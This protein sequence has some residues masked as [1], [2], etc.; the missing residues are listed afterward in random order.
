MSGAKRAIR[1]TRDFDT[2]AD[3]FAAGKELRRRWPRSGH[4]FW[5]P[6]SDRPDPVELI[7]R[8]DRG[9]VA[10]LLP[11]RYGRMARSPFDFLRGSAAVMA[12]NFAQTPVT[13]PRVQL[14]G[15]A[16]LNNFGVFA[17]PERDQVFDINDFDETLPG[18][19]EWD[20]KR[21]ATSL[22]LAGRQNRYTHD[23][24]R[25]VTRRAVRSYRRALARYARM[26]YLTIWHTHFDLRGLPKE[27]RRS[28]GKEITRVL[29]KGRHRTDFNAFPSVAKSVRGGYRIREEQPLIIHHKDPADAAAAVRLFQNYLGNLPAD[30][31]MLLEHYHVADVA[32]KVVGVGSVGTDCSVLLLMADR[33]VLDPLFLQVKQALRSVLE[34]FAGA[35]DYPTHGR[36]V[37][38]GQHL[39][40]QASDE[41]LGWSTQGSKDYYVRQLRDMRASFDVVTRGPKELIGKGEACGAALA[42][43]H[44]RTG[45]PA[46]ISGYLGEGTAFDE[47][48]SRFG[49]AYAHQ[50]ERDY[51]ELVRAVKK[52]RLP[53]EAGV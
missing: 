2:R 35:S 26:R 12:H 43:A 13:G 22:V 19:W 37:V 5:R 48:I 27:A 11:I 47:A 14:C 33:D 36:R 50:T 42:R 29:E 20:V 40:Q 7:E 3:R 34:P 28:G 21:L 25:K 53:A 41:L 23:T 31:R 15:D 16:H 17:T 24:V 51:A 30:G 9:R 52:G 45:D 8:S 6:A 49:E 38:M 10:R 39:I 44:A 18:P 46:L 1:A 4:A 32:Q